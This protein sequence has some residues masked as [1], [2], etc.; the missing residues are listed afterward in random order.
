M[1]EW[2]DIETNDEFGTA[3]L[4]GWPVVFGYRPSRRS[5]HAVYATRL[6]REGRNWMIDWHN[7]WDKTWG[8]NGFGI[9]PL[10]RVSWGFG[11]FCPF[12]MYYDPNTEPSLHTVA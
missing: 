8:D 7:S 11:V 9:M 3:L 2:C 6:F 1:R 12:D 5:G 4:K 10:S